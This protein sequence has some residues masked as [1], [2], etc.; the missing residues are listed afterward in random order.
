MVSPRCIEES[1]IFSRVL[2]S[3]E[4]HSRWSAAFVFCCKVSDFHLIIPTGM[5]CPS[6]LLFKSEVCVICGGEMYEGSVLIYG[7]GRLTRG[8]G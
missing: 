5:L 2:D 1:I 8:V 6:G 7:I 4:P 3:V